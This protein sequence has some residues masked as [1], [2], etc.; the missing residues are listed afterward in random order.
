[1]RSLLQLAFSLLVTSA[2]AYGQTVT[3]TISGQVTDPSGAVI[4]HAQVVAE[5]TATGV[6]TPV[7]TNDSGS[8]SIRFLPIG[9]YKITATAPGFST[10]TVP[11]FQLQIDQ[12]AKGGCPH[13]GERE[14]L[15]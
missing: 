8:Y 1:M 4:P 15:G 2:M 12:T 9:S 13:G 5:N 7:T 10:V 11:A 6:Q 3:G 14:R